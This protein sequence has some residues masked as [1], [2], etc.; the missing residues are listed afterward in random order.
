MH[1]SSLPFKALKIDKLL[2]TKAKVPTNLVFRS[3]MYIL[4][5]QL[6]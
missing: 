3:L 5:A 1:V 6:S 4:S 2:I